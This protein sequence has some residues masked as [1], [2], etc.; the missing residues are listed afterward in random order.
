MQLTKHQ[1]EVKKMYDRAYKKNHKRCCYCQWFD[2]RIKRKYGGSFMFGEPYLTYVAICRLKDKDISENS[3][4]AL[5]C[6]Y[7]NLKD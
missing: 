2:Y 5:F 6:K 7:Y 4:K 1:Q 3:K